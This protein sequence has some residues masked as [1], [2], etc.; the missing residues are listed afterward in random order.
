MAKSKYLDFKVIKKH[1]R[2]LRNDATDSE[3][4]LWKQLRNRKLSGYK[5]LRQHPI[6]YKAD[7]KGLNYF[8]ADFYCDEK[9]IVIELDGPVHENRDEY[10][11]FRDMELKEIG[12]HVLRIKNDDLENLQKVPDKIK[13]AFNITH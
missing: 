2:E 6:V 8:I 4:L 11:R 5:F 13:K 12:I 9:K 1:V 10:D 3:K 7:Y